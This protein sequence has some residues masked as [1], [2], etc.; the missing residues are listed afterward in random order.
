M[1]LCVCCLS[2]F[3]RLHI[4]SRLLLKSLVI[5][6][7]SNKHQNI[8]FCLRFLIGLVGSLYCM[9]CMTVSILCLLM[10]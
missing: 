4:T 6:I 3:Q 9:D 5:L 8:L 2:V 7:F 1:E 10:L